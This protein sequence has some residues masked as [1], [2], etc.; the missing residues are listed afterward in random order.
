MYDDI[1]CEISTLAVF[2]M[3]ELNTNETKQQLDIEFV[4]KLRELD[5]MFIQ[6]FPGRDIEVKHFVRYGYFPEHR[7]DDWEGKTS[8]EH[9]S[10]MVQRV[11]GFELLPYPRTVEVLAS[12]KTQDFGLYLLWMRNNGNF[13]TWTDYNAEYTEPAFL[14]LWILCGGNM[15][16]GNWF[17]PKGGGEDETAELMDFDQEANDFENADGTNS[18]PAFAQLIRDQKYLGY[19][20]S[21]QPKPPSIVYDKVKEAV[22]Y[23]NTYPRW[24]FLKDFPSSQFENT[25]RRQ[26]DHPFVLDAKD[27]ILPKYRPMEQHTETTCI[28]I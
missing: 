26:E 7:Q 5:L 16:F 10:Q 4:K 3:N 9:Y 19:W 17:I 27:P 13:I 1:G 18:Q 22:D 8:F 25:T 21:K 6:L 14:S 11:C 24:L 23:R 15:L 12:Q 2:L 20:S 28:I